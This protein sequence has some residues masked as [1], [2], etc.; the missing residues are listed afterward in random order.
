M[1]N[2]EWTPRLD[3]AFRKLH[4]KATTTASPTLK[5]NEDE[6]RTAED[7][8]ALLES[9]EQPVCADL[10]LIKRVSGLLL[11]YSSSANSK[12]D[13][14]DNGDNHVHDANGAFEDWIHVMIKGSS[15]YIPKSPP[16]ERSPE[17]EQIMEGIKAQIAEKEYQRMVSSIDPD[18]GSGSSIA[19]SIR[20]DVKE[21]K[22]IKAHAIGII[23]VLYTGAAVFT[24]V[25][26]ISGHFTEDLGKR[27]LL[28]FL[29]FVL[30]VACEAYLYSR[31][32]S[33]AN[34]PASRGRKKPKLPD[35][36]VI[37]TRSFVKDKSA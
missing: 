16:K 9:T 4:A 13:I 18:A 5:L 31:H 33:A 6:T 17:L 34:T 7:V 25:F 8:G 20:Q 21:M 1:V 28:A 23:N 10:D 35:D 29:A 32:V 37:T 12:Q 36:V 30:I 15:V 22:E 24:A 2:L 19:G 3:K 26:M 11:K 14:G 27:V